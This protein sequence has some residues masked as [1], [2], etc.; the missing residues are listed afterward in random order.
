M[1]LYKKTTNLP[2]SSRHQQALFISRV[3]LCFKVHILVGQL[4]S[5]TTIKSAFLRAHYNR[6]INLSGSRMHLFSAAP[7]RRFSS[8]WFGHYAILKIDICIPNH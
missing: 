7:L 8:L 3:K 1:G 2:M 6:T 5:L 4:S